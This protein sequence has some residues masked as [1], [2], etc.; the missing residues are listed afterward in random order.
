MKSFM[1]KKEEVKRNWYVIDAEGQ[2]LGR[3]SSKIS[4]IL[5]GKN[6]PTYTPYVDTGDYVIVL[7][8]EKVR[9]TGNKKADKMFRWHTGYMGGL[10]ERSYGDMLENQ[11][12]KVLEKS[13]RGMLPK[14]KLGNAMGKKL[15]VYAGNEHPHEAQNPIK[16]EL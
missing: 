5:T 7:N 14:S 13:I 16:I 6:K 12:E 2:T 3:L 8:A 10:K 1:A 4:P 9:L 15:K 11:P